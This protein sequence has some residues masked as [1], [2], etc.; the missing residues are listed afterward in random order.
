MLIASSVLLLSAMSASAKMRGDLAIEFVR[1]TGGEQVIPALQLTVNGRQAGLLPP[2]QG[3]SAVLLLRSASRRDPHE[4]RLLSADGA[5][6]FRLRLSVG[7]EGAALVEP[8]AT[9]AC[10]RF[11]LRVV[12]S[13]LRA[14]IQSLQLHFDTRSP[15]SDGPPA[16]QSEARALGPS[17]MWKLRFISQPAGAHVFLMISKGSSVEHRRIEAVTPVNYVTGISPSGD[18]R[19]YFKKPGYAEC[20]RVLKVQRRDAPFLQVIDEGVLGKSGTDERALQPLVQDPID[21]QVPE[22][23]CDLRPLP[24]PS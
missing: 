15:S 6:A 10:T 16:C 20:V 22:V 3:E 2:A 21:A 24:I 19:I 17:A 7:E 8:A 9:D 13:P 14:G 11:N 4:L 1:A 18:T 23:R 5:Y 12:P